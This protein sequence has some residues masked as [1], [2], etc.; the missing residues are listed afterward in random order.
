[1]SIGQ[2][3]QLFGMAA[4]VDSESEWIPLSLEIGDFTGSLDVPANSVVQRDVTPGDRAVDDLV[5]RT[6]C[7]GQQLPKRRIKTAINKRVWRHGG[8]IA[9]FAIGPRCGP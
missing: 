8:I 3:C 6:P 9:V 5:D 7:E 4:R 2:I 1:M